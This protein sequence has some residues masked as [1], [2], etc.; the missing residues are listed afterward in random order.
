M[1]TRNLRGGSILSAFDV[2]IASA[3][4]RRPQD[5]LVLCSFTKHTS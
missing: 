5:I 4:A 2:V 1:V 3:N